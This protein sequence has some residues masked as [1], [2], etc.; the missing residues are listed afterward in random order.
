[1]K[2]ATRTLLAA[3]FVLGVVT[4]PAALPA[5]ASSSSSSAATD[6]VSARSQ[7]QSQSQTQT[8]TQ[9]EPEL[10]TAM[11]T[12]IA[13]LPASDATAALVRVGGTDGRWRGSSGCTT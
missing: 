4:G 2:S 10:A 5:T 3:A 12:A 7:S 9:T 6:T 11:E 1:M 8:Q 13:G